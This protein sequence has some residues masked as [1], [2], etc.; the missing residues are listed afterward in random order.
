[1]NICL[2]YDIE[3]FGCASSSTSYFSFITLKFFTLPPYQ[4]S[5]SVSLMFVVNVT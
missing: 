5:I 2:F 1:M 3:S 4:G